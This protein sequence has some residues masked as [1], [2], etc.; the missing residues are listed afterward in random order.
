VLRLNPMEGSRALGIVFGV[1]DAVAAAVVLTAVFA[2][3]PARSLIVDGPAAI[4]AGLFIAASVG[5]LARRAWG[6]SVARI[7]A[8][9]ALVTALALLTAIALTISYLLGIYGQ[10][11][12]G[13]AIVFGLAAAVAVPYLLVLPIAQLVWARRKSVP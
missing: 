7:A 10:V 9:V 13:G 6:E 3:L 11:G 4:V 5:L 2:G 1:A 12:R 8:A